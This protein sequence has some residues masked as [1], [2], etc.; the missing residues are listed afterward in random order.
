M[1]TTKTITHDQLIAHLRAELRRCD[2]ELFRLAREA[3]KN[4][5]D[6]SYRWITAF[7]DETIKNPSFD[8]IAT[9]A[10]Y[11]GLRVVGVAG[12][13]HFNAPFKPE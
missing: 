4:K 13:K 3:K 12:G 10:R 9:L 1:S 11:L 5:H 7:R 6:I 2:G 8:K